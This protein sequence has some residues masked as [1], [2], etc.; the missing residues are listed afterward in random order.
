MTHT[1][2][3]MLAAAAALVLLAAAGANLV[4]VEVNYSL[5]FQTHPELRQKNFITRATAL[6]FCSR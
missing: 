3:I 6:V 4:V 2:K 5:E 1:K